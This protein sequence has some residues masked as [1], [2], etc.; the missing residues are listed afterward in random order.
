MKEM[1]SDVAVRSPYGRKFTLAR[2]AEFLDMT[3]GELRGHVR[4]RSIT[5]H[6]NPGAGPSRTGHY[7]FYETEL[8]E[9][10]DRTRVEAQPTTGAPRPDPRK[11]ARYGADVSG[12]MPAKRTFG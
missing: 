10:I 2:A 7:F 1:K 5:F 8:L 9:F 11:P 3:T 6:Q 4:R 12:L